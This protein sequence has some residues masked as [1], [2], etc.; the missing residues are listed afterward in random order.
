MVSAGKIEPNYFNGEKMK[1]NN[2]NK[3]VQ[4]IIENCKENNIKP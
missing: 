2:I 1:T 4:C 3:I